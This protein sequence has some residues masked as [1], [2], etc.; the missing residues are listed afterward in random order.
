MKS[1]LCSVWR[2]VNLALKRISLFGF[3]L[4]ILVF[5]IHFVLNYTNPFNGYFND[6]WYLL[7]SNSKQDLAFDLPVVFPGKQNL[8]IEKQ[9]PKNSDGKYLY[10]FTSDQSVCVFV[11]DD[12]VYEY[13]TSV[14]SSSNPFA[15]ETVDA[16]HE[17][18]IKKEYEGKTIKFFFTYPYDWHAGHIFKIYLSK[19]RCFFRNL[20]R[21]YWFGLL[22]SFFCLLSFVLLI[23]FSPIFKKRLG[24]YGPIMYIAF[25]ALI[26]SFW[27]ICDNKFFIFLFPYPSFLAG[28]SIVCLMLIDMPALLYA[29]KIKYLTCIK[30]VKAFVSVKIIVGIVVI[31]L[32]ICSI[33]DIYAYRNVVHVYMYVSTIVFFISLGIGIFHSRRKDLRGT[34]YVYLA[35]VAVSSIDMFIYVLNQEAYSANYSS[36]AASVCIA[37]LFSYALENLHSLVDENKKAN[38]YKNMASQDFMTG[39]KNKSAFLRDIDKLILSPRIGVLTVDINELKLINDKY[40]HE[41]GDE[42]VVFVADLLKDMFANIGECYRSGTDEFTVIINDCLVLNL[43]DLLKD[44]LLTMS[45]KSRDL[46]YP[47]SVAVGSAIFDPK[48]DSRFKDTVKR[49]KDKMKKN[50]NS[51]K[52]AE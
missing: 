17:I 3:I 43:Y 20:V 26:A 15:S 45:I 52:L 24:K 23:S 28:V 2:I 5:S 19:P 47:I 41:K 7:D 37:L 48:I 51:Q 30:F 10:F 50:K 42:A 13:G 14:D 39:T 11:D 34:F 31:I 4:I 9:L 18:R 49:A 25:Y 22:F 8:Q 29:T 40:G 46:S 21:T 32:E 16:W 44:F 38:M 6:E 35:V 12:L 33:I 36:F 27:F 1:I